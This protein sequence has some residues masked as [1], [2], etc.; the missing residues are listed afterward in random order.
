MELIYQ[1]AYRELDAKKQELKT[2]ELNEYFQRLSMLKA[3]DDNWVEQVD[4]LQQLQMA[5]GSQ[6]L[7]QKNPIVEYYQ[8]AYKGF[9]AMKRQIRKDMVRNLLLSQVQVTKKGDIIS[10]FP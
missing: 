7:S 5:I 9:E 3:V 6:Q 10:H 8:E 1:F 4:Y 2:K